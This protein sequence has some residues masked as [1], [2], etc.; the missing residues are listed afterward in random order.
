MT[1]Y[2]GLPFKELRSKFLMAQPCRAEA[3]TP[4]VLP[5]G[6]ELVELPGHCFE[7]VG[8][9]TPDDTLYLGDC[10]SS[11]ETLQKYGIGYLWDP[12]VSIATLERVKEMKAAR[13]VPSHAPMTEDIRELAQLNIDAIA[14]VCEKITA[15]CAEPMTFEALLAQLFEAYGLTMNAQQYALIGSTLRSYLSSLYTQGKLTIQF[16]ENRMEWKTV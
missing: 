12:A 9:R 15:L 2:G 6:W 10:V 7:M 13:F 4:D 16:T 3:L 14:A 8:F 5:A 11:R 1:L